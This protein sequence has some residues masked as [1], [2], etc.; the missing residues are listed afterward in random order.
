MNIYFDEI[1]NTFKK[2]VFNIII[3]RFARSVKAKSKSN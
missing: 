3:E 1:E 2:I